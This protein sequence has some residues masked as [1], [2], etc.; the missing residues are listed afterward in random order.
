MAETKQAPATPTKGQIK[1]GLEEK[2]EQEREEK[3]RVSASFNE[4][5]VVFFFVKTHSEKAGVMMSV[6]AAEIA[7]MKRTMAKTSP[8]IR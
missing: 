6:I 3:R 1:L 5:T 7:D 8:F 4:G 2:E